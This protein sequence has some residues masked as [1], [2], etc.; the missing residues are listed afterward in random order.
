MLNSGLEEK[1]GNLPRNL[2]K[3]WEGG[4]DLRGKVLIAGSRLP[5]GGAFR[6]G[7]DSLSPEGV[8]VSAPS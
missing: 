1:K 2:L 4:L 3:K 8:P 7:L 6:A 5:H